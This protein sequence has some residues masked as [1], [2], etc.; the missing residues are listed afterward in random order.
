[1]SK[2][3]APSELKVAELRQELS[4]RGLS[5]KGVKKV[6]VERLT[7]A[8]ENDNTGSG[9]DN[10]D[11]GCDDDGDSEDKIEL[12]PEEEKTDGNMVPSP[13]SGEGSGPVEDST[14]AEVKLESATEQANGMD[15]DNA[16][17]D[18]AE[19][20]IGA[21]IAEENMH[22]KRKLSNSAAA[23]DAGAATAEQADNESKGTSDATVPTQDATHATEVGDKS[24]TNA[25]VTDS[26]YIKNL[27]RP[28]TVFKLRE[29]LGRYGAIKDI[30]LNSIKTRAYVHFDSKETAAAAFDGIN[31]TKFP[32]EHGKTLECGV[33]THR[34]MEELVE[35]E[36]SMIE[37]VHNMDL[38][39]T[40]TGGGNC[41]IEL[42]NIKGR[43]AGRRAKA[44][45]VPGAK[46]G[47]IRQTE[48]IA[49]G[50][51]VSLV[52]A[53]TSAAAEE[54]KRA[55]KA[56]RVDERLRKVE[57]RDGEGDMTSIETDALTRR[58]KAQPA[59]T[60]RPLTD[61]QVAAKKAATGRV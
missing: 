55:A 31:G 43:D 56:G 14:N 9:T 61:D 49:G 3:T 27:E 60:F 26:L 39:A 12:L 17:N 22:R 24:E 41:R 45:K 42:V 52:V 46:V 25:S 54:A 2:E 53:A 51:S 47:E 18:K 11:G 50:Q 34:R 15:V 48:K 59:I 36:V 16:T 28:L 1:M 38:I 7:E 19:E 33:I 44:E 37:A 29:L 6:L 10:N 4:A 58:T 20:K 35:I 30:W 8:L 40:P 13:H 23:T 32:P 21:D 5:T 57:H